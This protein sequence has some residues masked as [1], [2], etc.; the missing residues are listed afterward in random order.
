M[1]YSKLDDRSIKYQKYRLN[2]KQIIC[3]RGKAIFLNEGFPIS[4]LYNKSLVIRLSHT[5]STTIDG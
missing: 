4:R 3:V 2:L 5:T 1:A